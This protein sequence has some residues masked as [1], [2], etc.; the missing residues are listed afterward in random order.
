M[1]TPSKT[2]APHLQATKNL[3]SELLGKIKDD[4]REAHQG[5]AH[6]MNTGAYLEIRTCLGFLGVEVLLDLV[7]A[8]GEKLNLAH[9]E[10]DSTVAHLD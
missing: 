10:F 9:V 1:S 8:T 6:A 5:I 3:V 7:Q 4:D 2:I